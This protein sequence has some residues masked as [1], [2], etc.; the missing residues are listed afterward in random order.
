MIH[1]SMIL[2]PCWARAAPTRGPQVGRSPAPQRP[3]SKL[4]GLGCYLIDT[5]SAGDFFTFGLLKGLDRARL[6]P[7]ATSRVL[8][9]A[10]DSMK[11]SGI[12]RGQVGGVSA[13]HVAFLQRRF[14]MKWPRPYERSVSLP[15]K[16]NSSCN[17]R[18]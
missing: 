7:V 18:E 6:S 5:D 9:Q 14:E 4:G 13:P 10:I 16:V 2:R 17:V 12:R 15:S 3:D 8:A 1:E 11:I